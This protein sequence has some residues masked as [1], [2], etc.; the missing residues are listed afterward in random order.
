MFFDHPCRDSKALV[1]Q[2]RISRT[3]RGTPGARVIWK[4]ARRACRP[5]SAP[6]S[7]PV[8]P[9]SQVVSDIRPWRQTCGCRH[10]V[11]TQQ[12]NDRIL[13]E[14]G[15]SKSASAMRPTWCCRIARTSRQRGV[16]ARVVHLVAG[17][18]EDTPGACNS[19]E[20]GKTIMSGGNPREMQQQY[21]SLGNGVQLKRIRPRKNAFSAM[22][23]VCCQIAHGDAAAANGDQQR[24]HQMIRRTAD[25]AHPVHQ[26]TPRPQTQQAANH[27]RCR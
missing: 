22:T 25:V 26:E 2:A 14:R 15:V 19:F 24:E 3:S 4:P 9:E 11:G 20:T 18:A 21:G 10:A 27:R 8:R 12:R 23:S 13:A 7:Q 6:S 1:V 5:P 16:F 17:R